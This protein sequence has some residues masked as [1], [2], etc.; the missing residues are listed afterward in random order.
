MLLVPNMYEVTTII[1]PNVKAEIVQ[2]TIV[3]S[4]ERYISTT[5]IADLV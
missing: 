2:M 4:V 1:Q 3:I 5:I